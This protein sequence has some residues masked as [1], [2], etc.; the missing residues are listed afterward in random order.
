MEKIKSTFITI[1]ASLTCFCLIAGTALAVAN[2]LTEDKIAAAKAA[3]LQEAIKKVA[4]EFDN[5]PSA[6]Q[7]R[8][9][10]ADGDSLTIYPA[11]KGGKLVGAAVE[12]NTKKGF[13]GEI[14]I[15]VGFDADQKIVNYSVLE[16]NETPGLGSKME[17]WFRTDKGKQSVLGRDM[18]GGALKVS[19]DG[20]EVDA[21]TAATISS[22]AFLDAINRAYAAYAQGAGK[23]DAKVDGAS[24][25]T[26]QTA[27]DSTAS[28]SHSK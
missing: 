3:A 10:T 9:A 7:Y 22:R 12:T 23:G 4:P 25:A 20:G 26:Q 8:A 21:I 17:E 19:K 15:M 2:K 13:G 14:R 27:A 18:K 11:K 28:T 5:D 24:G 16:H 1:L 6:E